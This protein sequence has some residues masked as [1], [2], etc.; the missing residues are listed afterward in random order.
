MP[1]ICSRLTALTELKCNACYRLRSFSSLTSLTT[2]DCAFCELHEDCFSGL[3]NLTDLACADAMGI[4]QRSFDGLSALRRLDCA[5]AISTLPPHIHL[6]SYLRCSQ[7]PQPSWHLPFLTTLEITFPF[8]EIAVVTPSVFEGV[9]TLQRLQLPVECVLQ[10][11]GLAPLV[12]LQHLTCAYC[13]ISPQSFAG[14]SSLTFLDCSYA[15]FDG[16]ESFRSSLAPYLDCSCYRQQSDCLRELPRAT[17]LRSMS[18]AGPARFRF[19]DSVAEAVAPRYLTE[20]HP[21][22]AVVAHAN[23]LVTNWAMTRCW[24]DCIDE[25]GLR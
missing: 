21:I 15:S 8:A 6:L 5:R 11:A 18:V 13:N 9:T 17:Q 10:D 16:P 24:P 1:H 23:V 4:T 20:C 7:L 2:L 19:V 12:H 22:A 25:P 3:T 14:L